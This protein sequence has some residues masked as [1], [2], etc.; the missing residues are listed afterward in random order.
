MPNS[1]SD[2]AGIK[3]GHYTNQDAGTGCTVIL[4]P[5]GAVPGVDVRGSAPGTHE[6][7]LM[8]PGHMIRNIHGIALSGGSAFGLET[9][10][11]VM[12]YLEEN[13]IGF[14][15][16]PS[17][18]PIVPA[19]IIFDLG[20]ITHKIRPGKHEGYQAASTANNRSVDQGNI[21]AGTGATVGKILGMKN[22]TKGGLGTYSLNING[23]TVGALAIVNA[24]GDVVNPDTGS[25]IAGPR[26]DNN[27]GFVNT[28]EFITSS[29]Y[30][31]RANP[32]PT[33]TTLVVV[34]TDAILTKE[35]TNKLAQNGQNGLSLAIR[36]SHTTGDGDVVFALSTGKSKKDVDMRQLGV[37]ASVAVSN[38]IIR[39]VLY[40][41]SLG[42]LPSALDVNPQLRITK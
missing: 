33:N 18:V 21:G 17:V 35:E 9:A 23:L 5:D 19:A 25:I 39:G 40:A 31:D 34:A 13:G 24:F 32:N 1:I 12:G 42:G 38:A 3:V 36:P 30:H 2:V 7:D 14:P 11:G 6:T 4:C 28:T 16:G 41:K 26:M 22:A 27:Q 15:A 29:N 8:R 37:A 10:S 20:F